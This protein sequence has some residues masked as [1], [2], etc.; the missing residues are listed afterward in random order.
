MHTALLPWPTL[1]LREEG[2]GP[3]GG[4][5]HMWHRAWPAWLSEKLRR[6]QAA[7][8]AAELSGKSG[9]T[10][11]ARDGHGSRRRPAPLAQLVDAGHTSS[12]GIRRPERLTQT[13][14]SGAR[15]GRRLGRTAEAGGGTRLCDPFSVAKGE[16]RWLRGTRG[17]RCPPTLSAERVALYKRDL[18]SPRTASV[19]SSG[20]RE[21][22][23]DN[24]GF[25]T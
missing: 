24:Y 3:Q 4:T 25:C 22:R 14:T 10:A 13:L 9:L 20:G 15:G 23:W 12:G 21:L 11:M 16:Q 18:L 7:S 17:P 6:H 8:S 19:V 5:D 1:G 2:V